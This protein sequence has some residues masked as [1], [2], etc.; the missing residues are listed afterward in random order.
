MSGLI[1]YEEGG[2]SSEEVISGLMQPVASEKLF[3]T[4]SKIVVSLQMR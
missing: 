4:I 1:K 3:S 2:K